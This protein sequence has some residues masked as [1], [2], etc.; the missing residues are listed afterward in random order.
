MFSSMNLWSLLT[1]LLLLAHVLSLSGQVAAGNRNLPV[2]DAHIHYSSDVWEAIP[3]DQAVRRLRK[4]GISRALV[5]STDDEGTQMLYKADPDLVVPEL[6]PYRKRGTLKTW[7]HDETVIPY[8]KER[9]AK[10]RYVAIGELHIE[11]EEANLPVVRD[12]V[13]LAR[14]H[15]LL[16]HIHSDA[17]ALN[18]IFEQDP[19][20]RILWAHAGF[21]YGYVVRNMLEKHKNLWADLSFRREIYNNKQFLPDWRELLI[22]HADRFLLGVDTYT[23]QRWLQL[24]SVMDWQYRLL[25]SLPNDVAR[26]I[27]FENGE[28]VV[29]SQFKKNK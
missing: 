17:K 3:P 2:F 11:N 27:A 23:P 10:Y 16:L 13:Q 19:D 14:Q 24:E 18:Y 28:R 22:D 25:D 8:L 26:K 9:L 5:S 7:M 15:K 6:R 29:T 1:N 21:E 4:A 12:L 20:A